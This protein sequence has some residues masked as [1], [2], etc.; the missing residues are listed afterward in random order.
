MNDIIHI[1]ESN[2]APNNLYSSNATSTIFQ[3]TS[4]SS[5]LIPTII[6]L[7]FQVIEK[8]YIN[9]VEDVIVKY[10]YFISD[11]DSD[12]WKLNSIIEITIELRNNGDFIACYYDVDVYGYGSKQE[13]AIG[14]LKIALVNQYE[15]LLEEERKYNLNP[16]L[17]DQLN[18][19]KNII[20]LKD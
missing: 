16:L 7:P 3:E 17:A 18:I 9:E 11:L 10:E 6:K 15:F 5:S 20:S 2:F 12:N 1:I 19:L 4:L 14:D 13:E 8:N